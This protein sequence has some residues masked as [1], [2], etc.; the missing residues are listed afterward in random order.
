MNIAV[1]ARARLGL[2]LLVMTLLAAC[3]TPMQ[4]PSQSPAPTPAP[5]SPAQPRPQAQSAAAT[6]LLASARG[7]LAVG[8]LESAGATLERALRIEP[9]N[10][11]LWHELARLRLR[12]GKAAEAR[13]L[14]ARSNSVAGGDASVREA[15]ARLIDETR[16]M[17]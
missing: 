3:G 2:P 5:S 1:L 13:S 17:R 10:P 15:N 14:A 8:R 4:T 6:Q 11:W 9:R 7:D 12:E 16:G